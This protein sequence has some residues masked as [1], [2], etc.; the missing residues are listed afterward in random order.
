MDESPHE[1]WHLDKRFNV[2]HLLSTI[3]LAGAMF[4]WASSMESRVAVLTAEIQS[5]RDASQNNQDAMLREMTY[6]RD[7]VQKLND[8]IDRLIEKK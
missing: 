7:N 8:K 2:G 5:I 6:L 3:V 1:S 4:G